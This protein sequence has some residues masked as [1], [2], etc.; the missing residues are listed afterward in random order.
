[1]NESLADVK[2]A[3]LYRLRELRQ[4]ISEA[5]AQDPFQLLGYEPNCLPRHAARAQGVP[6]D[7]L[8]APCG[9]CPQEQFHA[10][11][12]F[13]VLYGGSAGGGK[14]R[15]LVMEALRACV[16]HPGLRVG[17]FRRTYGELTESLIAELAQAD[18]GRALGATWN[19]TERE[20]RFGNGSLIMF[21]YAENMVDAT[22][23][24]GGQYQLLLFDER[25]LTP[26]DVV[27][28]LY[29]RLRSG[30]ADIPVLG[31]RSGTNPGGIGH[32]AVKTRYIDAT[33]HGTKVITDVRDRTVRFIQARLSDNPHVNSEYQKDLDG[34]PEG[35]RKAFR[36]GDWDVF[37][38]QVFCYDN[39]VELLTGS[40]WKP[41]A[42]V[43][44]DDT[45]ATMDPAGRMTFNAITATYVFDYDG[46]MHI[47]EGRALDFAVTSGHK[48]WTYGR[49]AKPEPTF[50]PI[51][52]LPTT[53]VHLR[54]AASW[55]GQHGDTYTVQMPYTPAPKPESG[56]AVCGIEKFVSRKGMCDSCYR[57]W[58]RADQ[59]SD[60]DWFRAARNDPATRFL[61]TKVATFDRGDWSELLG[62]YLSEGFT[63]KASRASTYAGR[64][65]GFGIA[66]LDTANPV[67]VAS[68]HSLLTRMGFTFTFDGCRFR[69]AHR[70]LGM[71]FAQFGHHADK[72]IPR[73]VLN[74]TPDHLLR[75]FHSLMNGDGHASKTSEGAFLY[76]STSKQLADDVQELC[77]R[78]GR[79]ATVTMVSAKGNHA[80][81]YRVSVYKPGHDRSILHKKN[82]RTEHYK[83]QV[84]CVTVE[85]HHTVLVRRNGK[86][87]W[88]G[89][90]EWR[91]DRHVVEPF[92]LDP[93]YT[94]GCGID[95]GY[96]HP[97]VAMWGARDE[98]GRIWIHREQSGVG[99]A[100]G[101]QARQ[102][103]A[104]EHDEPP[105][106][107]YGDPSMWSQKG[108][109][110][111]PA[112]AYQLAGLPM[113]KATN[114]RIPGWQRVH[115]YLA[116]APACAIHRAQ[117]WDTCPLLHVFSTCPDLIRTLPYA[118]YK[119]GT[120]DVKKHE[121]DDWIDAL[122]YLL[123][124][125]GRGGRML[126]APDA[127]VA[128]IGGQPLV[129][130]VQ[131]IGY[132]HTPLPAAALSRK[133]LYAP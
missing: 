43:L 91:H 24:Q 102:I 75:L 120:E 96:R 57:A 37:A 14:T 15:S 23:R 123:M 100:E 106:A 53:S 45:V 29:S 98:D 40:G 101:E 28:F 17:A 38:G 105:M 18:Y 112:L 83:G 4:Q 61:H 39:K 49:R 88:C 86:P 73:D 16:R 108:E 58:R 47:H 121:G 5:T 119:P 126:T 32:G 71:Y 110:P 8:P 84:A 44:R 62:W 11:T 117:G 79:V 30:R 7:L 10:A 89:N 33:E 90:T 68:I 80:A 127:P 87:M 36:D 113:V 48:M 42:N 41:V 65:Y 34:L 92:T 74:W 46:D 94:R 70:L 50:V 13:D 69:V 3:K 97:Y 118:P 76:A 116:D 1:M 124:G 133:S 20:L 66:Q 59:P 27:D 6:E 122:R 99:V 21:R 26:P 35:M 130:E 77:V 128:A 131:G 103:L 9:Q 22:R 104:A 64:V 55:D 82:I 25:T 60:M 125:I 2:L 115:T 95:Y 12:E 114:D 54:T 109:A 78:L 93:S 81:Q 67:K 19:G 107:H 72:F 63:T 132:T 31:I 51:E 129:R 52:H 111:A 85:P 56:C